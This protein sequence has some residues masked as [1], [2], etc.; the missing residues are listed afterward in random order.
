MTASPLRAAAL[1]SLALTAC[2]A[3]P[4]T[5]PDRLPAGT[6]HAARGELVPDFGAGLPRSVA[7]ERAATVRLERVSA[8]VPWPRGL[9]FRDGELIVLARG[10]HRNAGGVDHAVEDSTGCLFRVDPE[11]A[12]PVVAGRLASVAVAGNAELLAV[13]G[14]APFRLPDRTLEP[15]DDVLMDRPY[16]TLIH[17]PVSRNLFVCGYSGVDLPGKRFRKNATDSILRFDERGGR[18]H[19]VELHDPSVVPADELGYVVS[20]A[21]YPH[22]DPETSPAPHGWLNGPDGGCVAG[23]FLYC[24]AKDNHLVVRYELAGIRRDPAA[25]FPESRPVLGPRV[26]LRDPSGEFREAEL[27]GP[28]AAAV[29]GRH[30]YV[31]YRTSSVVVRFLLEP[32]GELVQPPVGELVAVFEPWDPEER[33]SANLIDMA[34]DSKGELFVS[35]SKEGRIWRV[36]VP[37]PARPFFGNDRSDRPTTAPPYADMTALLGKRTPTGNLAFDDGDRLYVCAGSYDTDSERIAGSIY[38]LVEVP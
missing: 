4:D 11:I 10:R 34:F 18:W 1:V 21:Y 28:S 9:V 23:E 7:R 32:S 26:A 20:N 29:S 27:L 17:D 30:L 3:A 25:G 15:I 2:T 6:V 13:P 24:V 12:E 14:G 35:C 5:G 36:G 22:H 33:R 38:R 8:G 37:D 19:A 16:C 31:G